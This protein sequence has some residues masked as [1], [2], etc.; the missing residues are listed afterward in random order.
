MPIKRSTFNLSGLHLTTYKMGQFVPITYRAINAGDSVFARS[1]HFV[2]LLG[3][4]TPVIHP[5]YLRAYWFWVSL[6]S[7]WPNFRE[8]ISGSDYENPHILPTIA[9]DSSTTGVGSIYDKMGMAVTADASTQINAFLSRS[10]ALI[11]NTYIRDQDLQTELPISTADGPDTTT[12]FSLQNVCW[13][14][15][16]FTAS[17]PWVQKGPQVY[18][19]LGTSAPVITGTEL[20]QSEFL[21]RKN[22]SEP[23]R[24][25]YTDN[26]LHSTGAVGLGMSNTGA[27][28]S[29]GGTSLDSHP[30][31]PSNLYTDLEE[32]NSLTIPEV[33]FASALQRAEE[34]RARYGDRYPE[35]MQAEFGVAPYPTEYNYP[36]YLGGGR[37]TIQFSEVLGTVNNDDTRIGQYGGH[38]SGLM[39][40]RPVK[41]F[42]REHGLLIL[43]VAM[44]PGTIYNQGYPRDLL[45]T[46]RNDY[47][48]PEL[49][50]V[51]AQEVLTQEIDASATPGTVFGYNDRYYYERHGYNT[52]GGDFRNTLNTWTMT[53]DF[54]TTP[55]LNADFVSSNPTERIFNGTTYD[56]VVSATYAYIKVRRVLPK[57]AP[58]ILQ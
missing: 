50:G 48:Q 58:H 13:E 6:S 5:V 49:V 12:D 56:Q 19:P 9:F 39:S 54:A 42:A 57:V 21:A 1:S 51:G 29:T 45:R 32:S 38:A 37:R 52:S 33:R 26:G 43:C 22:A 31:A 27:T 14:K 34:N 8:W 44:Q 24:S 18:L 15:D 30:A 3:L 16:D 41:F 28:F 23:M 20:S 2:R 7:V 4:N 35:Y 11:W 17:R 55:S 53:R 46:N 25:R 40:S 36:V 10:Y 47:I